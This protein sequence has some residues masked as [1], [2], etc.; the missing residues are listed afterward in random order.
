MIEHPF[1]STSSLSLEQIQERLQQLNKKLMFAISNGNEYLANQIK[2]AMASL[3]Q[4]YA[5][6][7]DKSLQQIDTKNVINIE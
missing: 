5:D 3:Q 2:M 4:A 7:T 6:K 1:I